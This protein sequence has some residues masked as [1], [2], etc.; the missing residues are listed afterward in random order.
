MICIS[1]TPESRRLAK[2]DILNAS[3]MCDIVEV[4]LDR[5]IKVPDVGDMISGFDKPIMISCRRPQDGGQWSGSDDDR[6]TLLRNAIVAGP[7]YVELDVETARRVPRFGQ[8][9]RVIAHTSLDRPLSNIDD[10]YSVSAEVK[11]DVVKFTAPTPSLEDT[12]PLLVAASKKSNLPTVGIGLGDSG[13][14]FSL[15]GQR[16]GAPWVYAALEKGMEAHENQ[17]TVWD[18]HEIYGLQGVD[19]ETR[20]IGLT[21]YGPTEP[22]VSR[23]L[24]MAFDAVGAKLRCLPLAPR[25]IDKLGQ[26]LDVLKIKV[27]LFGP[28]HKL[29]LKAFAGKVEPTAEKT[30]Y[31]DVLLKQSSGWEGYNTMHRSVIRSIEAALGAQGPEDRPLDRRNVML[32]G[33]GQFSNAIAHGITARQGVLSI[34]AADDKLAQSAAE[35]LNSRFVPFANLYNTLADVVVLSEPNLAIGH[36][37]HEFNP[38]YL[39]ETMTV[40]DLTNYPGKSRLEDEARER[41]CRIVDPVEVALDQIEVQFKAV[42][43]KELPDRDAARSALSDE[44]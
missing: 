37:K 16:Y 39:K 10:L 31:I 2:V 43:G 25:G 24:N 1:V 19:K 26:M 28:H 35:R 34:T 40:L 4:C 44:F 7:A 29:D 6:M 18:L 3:R 38:S 22:R 30:G 21:G 15:L 20:F 13:L 8:T 32:I 27:L 36:R 5:L 42:T 12:W 14:T 41:G 9:Q 23:C 11:A 33:G 17:P